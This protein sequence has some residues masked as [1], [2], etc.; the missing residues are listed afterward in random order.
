MSHQPVSSVFEVVK[1]NV[2]GVMIDLDPG[3]VTLESNLTDLGANSV[4]RVEIVVNSMADLGVKV[5]REELQG[6]ANLRGLVD[7]LERHTN[8]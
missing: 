8:R 2:L 7:V 1:S 4:D 6:I 3:D 5:P